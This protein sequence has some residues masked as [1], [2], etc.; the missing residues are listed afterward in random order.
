MGRPWPSLTGGKW[1]VWEVSV[2]WQCL[3]Y[4]WDDSA[5]GHTGELAFIECAG[6]CILMM[7]TFGDF[8]VNNNVGIEIRSCRNVST[9]G[10]SIGP[11]LAILSTAAIIDYARYISGKHRLKN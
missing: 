6:I 1:R 2:P 3:A 4:E 7:K 9:S 11:F 10:A 8:S 5:D